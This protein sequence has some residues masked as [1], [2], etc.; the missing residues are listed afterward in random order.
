[1]PMKWWGWGE[2]GHSFSLPNAEGFWSWVSRGLGDTGESARIDSLETV[3][4]RASR[5]ERRDL[6]ALRR[7]AGEGA[8]VTEPTVRAVHSFGRGYCDLVR[9]RRGE[10]TNPT[11]AVVWPDTEEQVAAVL[12]LAATRGLAVVPFGGGTSVVG[13]LEPASDRPCI[14]LHLGRLRRVLEV[15]PVSGTV[16]AEA[17]I[18]GP[19]LEDDLNARGLTLGHFPQSFHYSSLG[20]WI[21]TRSAGQKSTLYGKIEERLLSLRLVSPGGSLSTP[22]VPA[23]AAGPDLNQ[24]IAGSEGVLGVITRATMRL[25]PLPEYSDYRGY[26][27]PSFVEGVEAARQLMRSELRPAVLRLSDETDTATSLAMRAP[28]DPTAPTPSIA[29]LIIGFEG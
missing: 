1:M 22:D 5:L 24:A 13:G 2:E 19:A 7:A 3:D 28:P 8:V 20:G 11:D 4:V 18:L 17:G 23:A 10:V 15:D 29:L 9:L 27:F 21:A 26:L 6:E 16:T 14:T 25:A 12:D